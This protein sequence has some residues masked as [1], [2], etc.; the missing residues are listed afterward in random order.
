MPKQ[1][2]HQVRRRLIAEALWRVTVRQGLEEVSLRHVATE[3]G[4]S[5]GL[6][7][8]YFASKDEMLLFALETLNQHVSH[9]VAESVA[10]RPDRNEPRALVR[11]VLL[12]MLPLDQERRDDAVVGFAFLA[13]AAV[14]PAIATTLQASFAQLQDFVVGEIH[15]AQEAGETRPGLDPE[16]ET[17]TL[18]ALLD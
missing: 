6:V 15:R 13:Q 16:R 14:R 2:D 1:V 10:A 9:R 3:A 11:A 18:L 7:Q 12:E 8:H 4:V 5:M 17:L